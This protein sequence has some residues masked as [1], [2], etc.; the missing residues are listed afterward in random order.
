MSAPQREPGAQACEQPGTKTGA[1]SA[2][3]RKVSIHAGRRAGG[4]C[5]KSAGKVRNLSVP[6]IPTYLPAASAVAPMPAPVLVNV[7][8]PVLRRESSPCCAPYRGDDQG[9]RLLWAAELE[10]GDGQAPGKGA[11]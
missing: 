5:G 7:P 8:A 6:S 3:V 4:K 9:P 2:K 11:W 10:V 1:E